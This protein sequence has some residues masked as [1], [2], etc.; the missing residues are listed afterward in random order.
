M[1]KYRNKLLR[2]L[3]VF[4]LLFSALCTACSKPAETAAADAKKEDMIAEYLAPV[5]EEADS[6]FADLAEIAAGSRPEE[7]RISLRNVDADILKESKS[8]SELL[9]DTYP[10]LLVGFISAS[11]KGYSDD[12]IRAIILEAK[13][14]ALIVDLYFNYNDDYI[15][16]VHSDGV[17]IDKATG[18][19]GGTMRERI[20]YDLT[21]N[22]EKKDE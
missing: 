19:D 13:E 4:A 5:Q 17:V 15:Y 8:L 10:V 14:R 11:E 20:D 18:K 6:Y 16:Q 21:E 3:V 9:T 7:V 22:R 2:R 1:D 12:E